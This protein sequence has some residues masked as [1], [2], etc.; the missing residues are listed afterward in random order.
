MKRIIYD[1]PKWSLY[2]H[3]A[4]RGLHRADAADSPELKLGDELF[5]RLFAGELEAIPEADLYGLLADWARRIHDTVTQLPAFERLAA[6]CRGRADESAMAVE[7]LINELKPDDADD[8]LRRS[9]RAACGKASAAVEQ[10]RDAMAGLEHV[11]FGAGVG[12]ASSGAQMDGETVRSLAAKLRGNVRLRQIALLAGRFK[13][14][15]GSKRRSRV[16]HG[17]DEIVDVETGA[18]LGRLLPL[19]LAI[20]CTRAPSS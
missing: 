1:V 12:S 7:A 4:A 6:E 3:R 2:L 10:L 19:E 8:V 16:R 11:A 20:S 9:A 5:E 17:A 14:I 18:D 13:R 15:A